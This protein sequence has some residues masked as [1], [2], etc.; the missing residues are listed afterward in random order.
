MAVSVFAWLRKYLT[1]EPVMLLYMTGAFLQFPIQQQ[2]VYQ[3]VCVQTY[4]DTVLCSNISAHET[5]E[6]FVE[7][8]ASGY[9]LYLNVANVIPSVLV[10][11]FLGSWTDKFGRKAAMVL[12]SIGAMIS[13]SNLIIQSY[14]VYAAVPYL[15]IGS[16]VAGLTGGYACVLMST[17][18]YI[19]DVTDDT[20]R[21]WRIGIVEAMT[22]LGATIGS[23]LGGVMVD[24]LGF[25]WVF[26]LYLI[27]NIILIAYV[28]LW[29]R[30]TV[31]KKPENIQD[32]P[33]GKVNGLLNIENVKM[34]GRVICKPREKRGRLHIVLLLC[35][36]F[37]SII[38]FMGW[39]DIGFLFVKYQLGSQ[40]SSTMYGTF[41][42]VSGILAFLGLSLFLPLLSRFL[43]DTKLGQV[44]MLS[45][46]ASNIMVAFTT[47]VWMLFLGPVIGLFSGFGAASLRSLLSKEVE[48]T[49]KGA[50][51]S[52][53]ASVEVLSQ[54]LASVLFNNLYPATLSFFPGF[55][56]VLM[57]GVM[58]IPMSILQWLEM[59]IKRTRSY[60]TLQEEGTE[61]DGSPDVRLSQDLQASPQ[62]PAHQQSEPEISNVTC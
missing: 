60:S 25:M 48:P 42:A 34:W 28:V 61:L 14:F 10:L 21:T 17:Y 45:R 33:T 47:T 18:T 27:L 15:F 16:I 62:S 46:A 35:A 1:V 57:G 36:F 58:I 40:W 24:Q 38:I 41:L 22:G 49:E 37:I 30:E 13:A 4:N 23:A 9:L 12:P 31:Q 32:Q 52:V 11:F 26:I 29:L 39:S 44:G 5:E 55:C 43:G 59:D 19:T 6:K 7:T 53:V 3:K 51:F 54:L 20:M 2:L 50:L 56:F 8:V